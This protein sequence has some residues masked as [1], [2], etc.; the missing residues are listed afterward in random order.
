VNDEGAAWVGGIGPVI[1]S[2][3]V[4]VVRGPWAA[5]AGK[6]SEWSG[7]LS[8]VTRGGLENAVVIDGG[9]VGAGSRFGLGQQE[10]GNEEKCGG[11]RAEDAT[12]SCHGGL[13]LLAEG[14]HDARKGVS[15]R[16]GWPSLWI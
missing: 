5:G 7:G 15:V 13:R 3:G 2:L 12:G 6:G 16:L 1:F 10:A 9:D 8:Q 14:Y 4:I 11:L